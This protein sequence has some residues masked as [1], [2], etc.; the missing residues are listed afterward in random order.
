MMVM[1]SEAKPI[2][3]NEELIGAMGGID[4]DAPAGINEN[5]SA[6]YLSDVE[7][8]EEDPLIKINGENVTIPQ[9]PAAA[10]TPIQASSENETKQNKST[11]V[12]LSKAA[13]P[14]CLEPDYR[15]AALV[16]YTRS[17][18]TNIIP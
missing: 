12:C 6:G 18:L 2:N 15:D 3:S 11:V 4:E 1:T 7:W 9:M 14:L 5:I 17:L 10:L 8:K 16:G 13:S